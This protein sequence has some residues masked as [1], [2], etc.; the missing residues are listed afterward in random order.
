MLVSFF[1]KRNGFDIL[2]YDPDTINNIDFEI[3]WRDSP[4]IC[5]EV[6]NPGWEG[7]LTEEEKKGA[8]KGLPKYISGEARTINPCERICY[9]IEKAREKLPL[10]TSNII[11]I[12]PDLFVSVT[13]L[14]SPSIEKLKEY[15]S[16]KQNKIIGGVILLEAIHYGKGVEIFHLFIE[17]E[18]AYAINKL[19]I[20]V[21][22][23][24]EKGSIRY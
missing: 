7:E 13:D 20:E 6:K 3:Q 15:L 12:V 19:P 17:N 24:L 1:F 8:R 16:I 22:E 9:P 18:V 14:F 23:G 2:R 10:K 21:S 5:C 4:I 11:A